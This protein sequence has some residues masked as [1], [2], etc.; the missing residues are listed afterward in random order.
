MAYNED[1]LISASA[2][3]EISEWEGQYKEQSIEML[4]DASMFDLVSADDSILIA[5]P[6][7]LA[8]SYRGAEANG[9][10]LYVIGVCQNFSF[11]ETSQIQPFKGIGSRRHLFTKTNSPVSAQMSRMLFNGK[12]L[13]LALYSSTATQENL[14]SDGSGTND[15][16]VQGGDS[17]SDA[18][19][20]TNIEEDLY[21]TP[22]GLGIIYHSPRSAHDAN[23][24]T[25]TAVGA[26]YIECCYLQSRSASVQ[27][28]Q[29]VVMEQVSIIADRVV[30]WD[31]YAQSDS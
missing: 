8:D 1:T 23:S 19:M 18:K 25:G 4:H 3:S 20:L 7:R 24:G 5:G 2:V 9:T 6:A 16:A 12:N 15:K 10:A 14:F 17:I 13:A 29:T 28:G 22:F 11:N 26:E 27:S 30:P 21:R 31:A